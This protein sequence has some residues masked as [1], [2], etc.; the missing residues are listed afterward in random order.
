MSDLP[1]LSFY[2]GMISLIFGI[3]SLCM[4]LYFYNQA[5]QSEIKNN[6]ILNKISHKTDTLDRITTRMLEKTIGHI[7]TSLENSIN[8][9]SQIALYKNI[10]Q[11]LVG[12]Q[13]DEISLKL[14]LFNYILKTNFLAKIVLS[15]VKDNNLVEF[16]KVITDKSYQHY[17]ILNNEINSIKTSDLKSSK[18]YESYI[19]NKE[20]YEK[21]VRVKL[22][23]IK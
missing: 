5:Y 22:E 14:S 12:I 17:E 18:L 9:I 13:T 3:I 6:E 11:E 7:T 4:S 16:S 8:S 20:L 21:V 10:N 1:T 2:L 15:H 19:S 23:N